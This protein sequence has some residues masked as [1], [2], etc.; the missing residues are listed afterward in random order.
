MKTSD[1]CLWEVF[2]V[3]KDELFF[4]F[5][6]AIMAKSYYLPAINESSMVYVDSYIHV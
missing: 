1:S 4:M 3:K 2:T 5:S 6:L